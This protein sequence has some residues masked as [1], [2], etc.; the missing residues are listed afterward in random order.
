M[1]KGA[2]MDLDLTELELEYH[3]HEDNPKIYMF[4]MLSWAFI[5]DCDLN[6]EVFRCLGQARFTI[7]GLYRIL[8]VRSY[9]G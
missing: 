2:T 4:L 9:P 6:S 8:N 1:A 5:S 7:W 3:Q